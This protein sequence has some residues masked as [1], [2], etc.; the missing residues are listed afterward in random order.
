MS[1]ELAKKRAVD[2]AQLLDV[3][4]AEDVCVFDVAEL[5]TV[6]EFFVIS[7]GRNTRHLKA[8]TREV[9]DLIEEQDGNIIGKEGTPDSGWMLIDTGDIV[10]HVFEKSRRELYNLEVLWGDAEHISAL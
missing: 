7:T 6:A 8:L 2:I 9:S 10:V 3:N 4:K 5:T 1:H